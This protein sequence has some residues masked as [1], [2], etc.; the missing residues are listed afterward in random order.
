[1]EMIEDLE[2][3]SRVNVDTEHAKQRVL[4]A[5]VLAGTFRVSAARAAQKGLHFIGEL[6]EECLQ[7]E[8][9]PMRLNQ[10]VK[11]LCANALKYTEQGEINVTSQEGVGTRFCITLPRFTHHEPTDSVELF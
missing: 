6:S 9:D 1:M 8:L 11:K 2:D 10:V 5:D 3:L 4:V 7:A